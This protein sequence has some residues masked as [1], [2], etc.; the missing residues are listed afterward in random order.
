MELNKEEFKYSLLSQLSQENSP[1]RV[2]LL[3][4]KGQR[5][6]LENPYAKNK[7]I[8]FNDYGLLLD[9][10][11]FYEDTLTFNA[12]F[13]DSDNETQADVVL[14]KFN[15]KGRSFY[16]FEKIDFTG[17]Y[18][19]FYLEVNELSYEK[20]KLTQEDPVKEYQ[21]LF[22]VETMSYTN[23]NS[24]DI[25]EILRDARNSL[26]DS[27]IDLVIGVS[28]EKEFR[29]FCQMNH[30]EKDKIEFLKKAIFQARLNSNVSPMLQIAYY[31]ERL[32]G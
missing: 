11:T 15:A 14:G 18:I 4:G 27:Y 7:K 6:S 2:F 32:K 10:S 28:F 16:Q 22:D 3:G 13:E 17:Q 1:I 9:I 21:L 20:G 25:L 8:K 29:T 24:H 5:V 30:L 23:N 12:T 19:V 26:S 31:L